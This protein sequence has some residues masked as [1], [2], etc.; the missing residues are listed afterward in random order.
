MAENGSKSL[1]TIAT[2]CYDLPM[3]YEHIQVL[4][5]EQFVSQGVDLLSV[6]LQ[7]H[8]ADNC[9]VFLGL[10][11]GS[12]PAP[13]YEALGTDTDV[14]WKNVNVFLVDER[15]VLASFPE[16]NERLVE[17]TLLRNAPIPEEQ[18]FFADPR[19]PL[20]HYTED[21]NEHIETILSEKIP[22][23]VTLGLGEDG[24]IA[25]LFP[26]VPDTAF[27]TQFAISTEC[28]KTSKGECLFPVC[29]RI[30]TTMPVLTGAH[31]KFIFL[32]GAKKHRV[33][34][35]MM[36]SDEDERRWPLKEVLASCVCT[37]LSCW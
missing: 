22:Y 36:T 33:W 34:E 3:D 32:S 11:G 26:P 37:V 15:Y 27:G 30:S 19:L 2:C 17:D 21:Y 18:L 35:E 6:S 1:P 23:I 31:E 8:I 20:E 13:I 14:E 29:E 10:S 25:S 16:S 12:T 4:S 28:P 24:H 5:E 9:I 7:K